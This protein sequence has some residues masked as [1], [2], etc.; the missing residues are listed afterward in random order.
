MDPG[1]G[2][3][4]ARAPLWTAVGGY[5]LDV[6]IAVVLM[7]A[8]ALGAVG[9][10]RLAND[11]ATW[12]NTLWFLAITVLGTGGAAVLTYFLRN[13]ANAS[14]RARSWAIARRP[15]TVRLVVIAGLGVF[16]GTWLLEEGLDLVG[17]QLAP[18][19]AGTLLA[20]LRESWLV[21][22]AFAVVL[23]PLYEELLFRRVLFG[24]LWKRGRPML[25]LVL[26]SAAFGLAHMAGSGGTPLEYTLLFLLYSMMGA[27][28]CWVY[29]R[30]GTLW[31][32][33]GVHAV[34]NLA[35]CLLV[36]GGLA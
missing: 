12:P 6:V 18:G 23:A 2:V 1:S 17:V 8:I 11:P 16:A 36:L 26:S 33:I 4:A 5:V 14:E 10:E 35:A 29:W 21:T 34:H 27:A 13:P 7:L 9:A 3:A 25:G 32:S 24:R 22:L 19:N 28:M 30:T 15:D 20:G 31:A